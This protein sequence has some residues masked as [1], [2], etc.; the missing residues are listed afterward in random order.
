M[1]ATPGE[2]SMIDD[3]WRGLRRGPDDALYFDGW[4]IFGYI[5]PM[6]SLVMFPCYADGVTVDEVGDAPDVAAFE[7]L[8]VIFEWLGKGLCIA[9]GDVLPRA[10]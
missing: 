4:R 6:V 2:I 7:R 9:I 3:E 5:L 10:R 8:G 1:A